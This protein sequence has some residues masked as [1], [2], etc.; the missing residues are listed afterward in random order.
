M[1]QIREAGG[2]KYAYYGGVIWSV[3][4]RPFK[5]SRLY[6]RASRPF[7]PISYVAI[8]HKELRDWVV[9]S[10]ACGH[11]CIKMCRQR[12]THVSVPLSGFSEPPAATRDGVYICFLWKP[13]ENCFDLTFFYVTALFKGAWQ[14][15][16]IT[17][18]SSK[19]CLL[20]TFKWVLS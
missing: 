4:G 1:I 8:Q 12:D 3:S 11:Q 17:L 16:S 5:A 9:K 19:S 10:I 6:V 13:F 14:W 2:R 20:R 7:C 15:S 18:L